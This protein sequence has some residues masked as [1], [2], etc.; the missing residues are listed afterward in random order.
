M[1]RIIFHLESCT[2]VLTIRNSTRS[3]KSVR[4]KKKNDFANSP[5]LERITSL[6]DRCIAR[7]KEKSDSL[8]SHIA[9]RLDYPGTP[10]C[11]TARFN[12]TTSAHLSLAGYRTR[13]G[14]NMRLHSARRARRKIRYAGNETFPLLG[15]T[16][17]LQLRN[18]NLSTPFFFYRLRNGERIGI[19]A[20]YAV[21]R[22]RHNGS[23]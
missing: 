17:R 19:V 22:G 3:R 8:I 12:H 16:L 18:Y 6:V 23:R 7:S 9:A 4:R 10:R 15:S 1:R 14:Y 5:L 21:R 11:V 20:L 13:G 2:S